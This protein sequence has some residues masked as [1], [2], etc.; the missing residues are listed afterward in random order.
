MLLL[1]QLKS[2]A[3]LNHKHCGVWRWLDR[4][5]DKRPNLLSHAEVRLLPDIRETIIRHI[6]SYIHTYVC[7]YAD[8]PLK[9]CKV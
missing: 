7:M 6:T 4:L 1:L 3:T 2:L 8:F 9:F 5:R